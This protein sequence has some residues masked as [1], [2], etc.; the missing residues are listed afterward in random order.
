MVKFA[1]G[2]QSSGPSGESFPEIVRDYREHLVEVYFPWVHMP[3]GRAS[4][5]ESRGLTDWT[6]QARLEADLAAL[7]DMGLKLDLLLNANCYGGKAVS[8]FL[9]N[10]VGSLLAHLQDAIGGVDTVT[11]SSLAIARTIRRHF[12]D[13]DVRASVNMRI[14]TPTAMQYVAGLFTSY[15]IQRDIQRRLTAVARLRRW[16][17]SQNKTLVMLANSGCLRY[18]PG[19]TF[20]DNMVAHDQE[21]DETA[22]IPGW[23]P[24]V[25]WNLC[26]QRENWPA[27]LQSTWVRPEDVAR[28]EGLVDIVKLATRMHANPRLVIH[29]YASGR[30]RGNL[31]D[32]FEPG[33]GPALAP[34]VIDSTALPADW[35]EQTSTCDGDCMSCRYCAEAL[36]GA[37][38][39]TEP[40]EGAAE[41]D[42]TDV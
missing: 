29:A 30:Y 40:P 14:G 23:T 11:T 27:L 9:E 20:H 41:D 3:S 34:H 21:I 24:H 28:Y 10:Q 19:Q 35:F 12:P 32:L 22:N 16:A 37:L 4:L 39:N 8:L 1:V 5:N 7:R 25:C 18:C 26:R 38:V 36:A 13:I 6:A 15:C 42:G 17:D 33:F 31:L 2:Y